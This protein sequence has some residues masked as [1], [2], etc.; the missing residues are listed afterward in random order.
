MKT[1]KYTV[2]KRSELSRNE[3]KVVDAGGTKVLLYRIKDDFFATSPICPHYGAPLDEGIMSDGRIICP[4]HHS[5]FD[6][7]SGDL[8]EP[9]SCDAIVS[10]EVQ[11]TGNDV[12]VYLP[13]ETRDRRL[14]SMTKRYDD[15]DDR[16]FVVAGGGASGYSAVQT[17]REDGFKGRIVMVTPEN[18]LPYDRPNLSK[19]YLQGEAPM[20]WM[21]LRPKGFFDQYDI[22]VLTERSIKSVDSR[23][24]IVTFDNGD[25]LPYA[26]LLLAMGGKARKLDIPG[27]AL[28]NI[29]TL[30]SF[31][32]SD[33][34]ID[35]AKTG[36]KVVIVGGGFI[37]MESAYSLRERDLEVTVVVNEDIPLQR[38][39]GPDIGKLLKKRHEKHGIRF[40]LGRT[41]REFTGAGTVSAVVLDNDETIETDF[42]IVGVG[43]D[44][45]SDRIQGIKIGNDGSVTVDE[46]LMS[47]ENIYA[48]GDIASFPDWRTPS[49]S[50]IEHWR[51]AEQQGRIAAHNMMGQTVTY[52]S[53]PFFW[54]AQ[55]G[56]HLRY[57]GHAAQWD[58]IITQG[59]IEDANFISYFVK[60]DKVLAAA[61]IGRDKQMIAIGE[62]MRQDCMPTPNE[63]RKEHPDMVAL[64]HQAEAVVRQ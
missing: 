1:T 49:R 28:G 18:R 64:V 62:L 16:T 43:V 58:E 17:L 40:K 20:E 12:S 4:W 37:G 30:R 6:I 5:A 22:E 2:A 46:F 59:K 14:P 47:E 29:F 11:V 7:E 23:A 35:A 36:K 24:R 13:E 32:D 53:I 39:F 19:E 55:A 9:P 42:V 21:P 38:A 26:K 63:I 3:M 61:G 51:T 27:S 60:D 15:Q 25:R 44:P 57:V 41:V 31:A 33:L 45:A 48:A 8:L 54:T 56:L 50:R 34:I 10:Y 52:R